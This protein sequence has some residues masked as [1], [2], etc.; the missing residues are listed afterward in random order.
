MRFLAIGVPQRGERASSGRTR[1]ARLPSQL[2]R[3][4]ALGADL[5]LRLLGERLHSRTVREGRQVR[6]QDPA[7]GYSDSLTHS[8]QGERRA[9][10]G[11]TCN[12][13]GSSRRICLDPGRTGDAKVT[14]QA[15]RLRAHERGPCHP[16]P[17]PC[18]PGDVLPSE[19]KRGRVRL[20]GP[21]QRPNTL[22]DPA[23]EASD[24]SAR[25]A[26]ADS[27]RASGARIRHL[28]EAAPRGSW[29]EIPRRVDTR[30]TR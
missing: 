9:R 19:S 10:R 25:V 6:W 16:L 27:T 12:R 18:K 22:W 2:P 5:L 14:S 11:L 28:Q 4:S 7:C 26:A 17:L 1:A 20:A 15:G 23:R 21:E 8:A 30:F 13:G 24:T 3:S 29:G